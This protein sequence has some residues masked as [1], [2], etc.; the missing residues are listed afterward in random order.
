MSQVN[1]LK[2]KIQLLR[3]SFDIPHTPN[4][5]VGRSER[6][7]HGVPLFLPLAGGSKPSNIEIW[8]G[9]GGLKSFIP[10]TSLRCLESGLGGTTF[11]PPTVGASTPDHLKW[12]A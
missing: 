8:G 7:L 4:F 9:D 11:F 12:V 5:T 2:F 10:C 1:K 6:R 3:Q